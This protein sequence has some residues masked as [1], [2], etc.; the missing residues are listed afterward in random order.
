MSKKRIQ[1]CCEL[2]KMDMKGQVYHATVKANGY[3]I[4]LSLE[5]RTV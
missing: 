4:S 5:Y 2:I 3:R 1:V